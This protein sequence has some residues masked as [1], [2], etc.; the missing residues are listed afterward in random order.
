MQLD[1]HYYGT[2]CMARAAGM[3]PEAATI[4]ATAA[5]FV[6]DNARRCDIHLPGGERLC[7]LPTAHHCEDG[8][9]LLREDQWHVWVPFH[10]LPGNE[11]QDCEQK[12]QCRA[13]SPLMLEVIEHHKKQAKKHY[14]LE[15]MG[16][17]AHVL[18]DTYSHYGFSGLSSPANRVFNSSIRLEN[19]QPDLADYLAAKAAKFNSVGSYM[20]K[21][22][23]SMV[24]SNFTNMVSVIKDSGTSWFAERASKGLGHG[25]VLTYPDRPYLKWSF[26]YE[27]DPKLQ[28]RDNPTTFMEGCKALH[29]F[30]ADYLVLAPKFAD[31]ETE[32]LP[33]KN[34][35][36]S[37]KEIIEFQ[38]R[39]EERCDQWIKR[40]KSG[41]LF[42]RPESIPPYDSRGWIEELKALGDLSPTRVAQQPVTRF[43]EAAKEH[44]DFVL[45]KLLPGHQ[46]AESCGK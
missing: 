18:M 37:V 36:S 42:G 12:L 4:A 38:G 10:F 26:E 45:W 2:W 44:R 20:Q 19:V 34:L 32:P 33:F 6:D 8:A 24:S 14:S 9:N 11:G 28:M 29:K 25:P 31:T 39:K 21:G 43:F 16:I 17:T 41:A 22:W 27:S 40:A 46:L 23:K 7:T 5:Q 13:G 3:T 15:L 30:F 1:M 35:R